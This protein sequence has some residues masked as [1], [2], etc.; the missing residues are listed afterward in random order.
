MKKIVEAHLELTFS[1]YYLIDVIAITKKE[2]KK[3]AGTSLLK[4]IL[5]DVGP[6]LPL[7]S[8]T[9]KDKYGTNIEKLYKN[10][11]INPRVNLGKIWTH[12]CNYQF[13]CP[14]FNKHCQCE[15][16]LFKLN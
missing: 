8:V 3:G 2:Q 9:W 4:K 6:D 10:H 5:T 7:Y 16:V 14:S 13:K 15:G 11:H 1:F 12:G